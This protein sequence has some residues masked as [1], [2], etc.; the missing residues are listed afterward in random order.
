MKRYKYNMILIGFFCLVQLILTPGGI[1]MLCLDE[2]ENNCIFSSLYNLPCDS[3][4]ECHSCQKTSKVNISFS[5]VNKKAAKK[6]LIPR[7]Y[8]LQIKTISPATLLTGIRICVSPMS[9]QQLDMH[10]QGVVMLT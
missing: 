2:T 8:P 1:S 3:D 4:D 7:Q 5:R 10:L 6:R 9:R